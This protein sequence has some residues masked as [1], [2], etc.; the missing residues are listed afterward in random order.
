MYPARR[1]AAAA[2]RA[3]GLKVLAGCGLV[4]ESAAWAY[5]NARI[6]LCLSAARDVGQRIFETAVC[7]CVVMTDDCP[8]F[9][10]LRPDG[11]WIVE[12]DAPLVE[13]VRSI[14]ANPAD[15]L[16]HVAASMA[17]AACHNWD[18]RAKEIAE[19]AQR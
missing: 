3:A 15:A 6:S 7:S 1:E 4:Y 11:L 5:Q 14:L 18:A 19:W 13:Q 16:E 8:D 10:H 9:R 17:W 12:P 2:L